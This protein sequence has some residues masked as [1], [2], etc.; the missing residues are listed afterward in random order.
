MDT[1]LKDEV[2]RYINKI[3][4]DLWKEQEYGKAAVMI[5]TGFSR[6]ADPISPNTPEIPLWRD[7]GK[8][9]LRELYPPEN[10]SQEYYEDLE[11]QELENKGLLKIASDYCSIFGRGSLDEL[12]TE[13]IPDEK[14]N[15]GYLHELLLSLPWSDVFTTNYDTLLERTRSKIYERKYSLVQIPTDIPN[16]V[17]PRIIK[18][19]GSFPSHKPFIF[20]QEDYKEYPTNFA[21]FTNLVRQSLME[22]T[23][24]LVGFSGNDPNFKEWKGWVKKYLKDSA[25]KIYLC[26]VL[27]LNAE[28]KKNLIADNIIPI[29]LAALFPKQKFPNQNK[30][31]RDALVWFLLNLNY[32]KPHD[33]LMWPNPSKNSS[34]FLDLELNTVYFPEIPKVSS[35]LPDL[36]S[37]SPNNIRLSKEELL[38]L[39]TRWKSQRKEYPGWVIA[40]EDVRTLIWRYTEYFIEAILNS[41]DKIEN[42]MGILLLYELNWRLELC[43][44]PLF[45]NWRE[46]IFNEVIKYNPYP[47]TINLEEAIFSP[48]C[49]QYSKFDW[50][51]IGKCWV[52]LAFS[53]AREAKENHDVVSFKQW[54]ERLEYVKKQSSDWYAKWYFEYIQ[55]EFFFFNENNIRELLNEWTENP[56][57][58]FWEVKRAA[59]LAELGEFSAAEN[60]AE[61][62]LSKIRGN[63][64]KNQNDIEFLS[65]EGWTMY[66]LLLLKL[67]KVKYKDEIRWRYKARWKILNNYKCS[68]IPEIEKIKLI[69]SAVKSSNYKP[70]RSLKQEFDPGR[71]SQ[72]FTFI[73]DPF[74]KEI[75][76][77]FGLLRICEEASIPL[78]MINDASVVASQLISPFA[79]MWSLSG[80]IR[81]RNKKEIVNCFNR[82]KI[83]TLTRE[84][85]E[86]LYNIFKKSVISSIENTSHYNLSK[87]DYFSSSFAEAQLD[88]FTILLSQLSVRLSKEELN[89]LLNIT[90]DLYSNPV[91]TQ[92]N[93]RID[94]LNHLFQRIFFAMTDLELLNNMSKL[95][96]LPIPSENG[97]EVSASDLLREPFSFLEW[98]KIK[99]LPPEF[100]RSSWTP[101]IKNMTKMIKI[102]SSEGR[103]RAS[104][105]I[106]TIN[107]MEGLNHQEMID[108]GHSLWKQIDQNTGFPK[109]TYFLDST[110][111]LFPQ[112]DSV[113]V[114]KCLKEGVLSKEI[115]P[116]VNREQYLFGSDDFDNFSDNC[117][118]S[119][120]LLFDS[121]K[122]LYVD[123]TEDEIIVLLHKIDKF[124]K[125]E[126][127]IFEV[128]NIPSRVQHLVTRRYV[129]LLKIISNVILPR[130]INAK[131]DE[132]YLALNIINE[133]GQYNIPII[134]V[135]PYILYIDCKS[136]DQISVRIQKGLSSFDEDTVRYSI[137]GLFLW[138]I[139]SSKNDILQPPTCLLEQVVEIIFL[140]R[141]PG[142]NEALVIASYL[143]R[144][145]PE[146][147]D[148]KLIFKLLLSLEYLIEETEYPERLDR[149]SLPKRYTAIPLEDLPK[150]RASASK[151]S[152]MMCKK[153]YNEDSNVPPVLEKWKEV[154]L[155]DPLP[156]VRNTWID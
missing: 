132:K 108:F 57:L 134:E 56:N 11:T 70:N 87:R 100:D 118:H 16:S 139:L 113:S 7:L 20:T 61:N 130:L 119:V 77:A 117:I 144:E 29:D 75:L 50:E 52:A 104:L 44:I 111:L 27:D 78:Y 82:T 28:D 93:S 101:H 71:V 3:R 85:V 53:L 33:K 72:S 49:E 94:N 140:R 9:L 147:F 88:L 14:Y 6:N 141:Q 114:T 5:G 156:E 58:P 112:I 21:P 13:S 97:F 120:P 19:H 143:V 24:C 41:L 45:N 18:L 30:R 66:L 146:I 79:P 63:L 145:V 107:E 98:K 124:W 109:D 128:G 138:I 148:E 55:F 1:E 90:I 116:I 37:M 36:G 51:E 110:F 74:T 150:I 135:S 68:P 31:H 84:E 99:K 133:I 47:E 122:K 2:Q 17:S 8:K 137:N 103:K 86:K 105:R 38:E 95:L 151:L 48:Y 73:E 42:P 43:L 15:P 83:A 64:Q 23:L 155:S 35:L 136:Y 60:I 69:L 127:Q 62:S 91:F 65:Q 81:S 22:N 142:L 40:P 131:D 59:I 149:Y 153:L 125:V 39:Y 115:P 76:S 26:G 34:E 12:L 96:S 123:W 102:G 89:D 4:T 10:Y 154:S 46:K 121:K 152:Y 126:K 106:A 80:V 92:T 67:N 129:N 25:R 32:G 54:I